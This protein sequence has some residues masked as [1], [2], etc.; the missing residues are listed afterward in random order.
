MIRS[1]ESPDIYVL[2]SGR[3]TVAQKDTIRRR[4]SINVDDYKALFSFLIDHHPSFS[5]IS[6]PESCPQLILIGWFDSN[7][8][9][10]DESDGINRVVIKYLTMLCYY[11]TEQYCDSLVYSIVCVST[12][13]VVHCTGIVDVVVY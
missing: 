13:F 3:A 2:I 8:N 5:G 10:T 7:A 4:V 11:L 1:G 9:N 12:V 6:R